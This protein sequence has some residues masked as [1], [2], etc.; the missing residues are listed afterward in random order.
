MSE[1]D[2]LTSAL[3]GRYE[4]AHEIGSGGM[5]PLWSP[6]GHRVFYRDG[7]KL[8]AATITTAPSL[9]VTGHQL[10]FE[11]DF[12]AHPDHANYDLSHDGKSFVMLKS[13]DD[14]RKLVVVLNSLQELRTKTGQGK[15]G[16]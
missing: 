15:A 8:M 5:E 16:K 7:M 2:T 13:A 3:A 6:D 10:L 4:I 9:A 1:I 12:D 14:E 11:G